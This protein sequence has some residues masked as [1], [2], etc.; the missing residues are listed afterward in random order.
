MCEYIIVILLIIIIKIYFLR[1]N[2]KYLENGKYLKLY[3][4]EKMR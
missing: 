3:I 4:C 2:W 1:K